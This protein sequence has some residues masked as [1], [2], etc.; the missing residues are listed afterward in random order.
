MTAP[1]GKSMVDVE[2]A[3]LV[4][5]H[6]RLADN[7]LTRLC[8]LMFRKGLQPGEGLLLE[9]TNQVHTHFMRFPIDI[10]HL[11]SDG[12][13]LRIFDAVPPWKICPLVK[14][15]HAVLELEAGKAQQAGVAVGDHLTIRPVDVGQH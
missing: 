11:S 14:R 10:V 12:E 5:E 7:P 8:G 15:S 9:P 3:A 1:S 4:V 2:R 13:V 6:L